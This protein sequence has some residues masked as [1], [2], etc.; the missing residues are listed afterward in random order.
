MCTPGYGIN[1][2]VVVSFGDWLQVIASHEEPLDLDQVSTLVIKGW[3]VFDDFWR[4]FWHLRR[5]P[6]GFMYP[7]SHVSGIR[8]NAVQK[9]LLVAFAEY[10]KPVLVVCFSVFTHRTATP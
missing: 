8:F 3:R 1:Q 7:H 2:S 10:A 9:R 6:V 5:S 4:W